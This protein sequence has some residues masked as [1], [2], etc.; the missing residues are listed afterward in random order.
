MVMEVAYRLDIYLNGVE[1]NPLT[2]VEI[3]GQDTHA[4]TNFQDM[5]REASEGVG[6]LACDVLILEEM[7]SEGF[8]GPDIAI[9]SGR[10]GGGT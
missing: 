2:I 4:G 5:G 9:G 10:T 1:I 8:L 6:N 3:L 7:L